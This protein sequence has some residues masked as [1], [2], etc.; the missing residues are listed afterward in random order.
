MKTPRLLSLLLFAALVS[1]R[2]VMAQ[3]APTFPEL[4]DLR[5][6]LQAQHPSLIAGDSGL[7]AAVVVIDTTGRYVRS[8]AFRLEARALSDWGAGVAHSVSLQDDTLSKRLFTAC[9]DGPREG[10]PSAR[11]VCILDGARVRAVDGMRFLT[12]RDIDVLK[13]EAATSRFGPDAASGAVVVT[14]DSVALARFKSVGATPENFVSFEGRRIRRRADGQPVIITVL[15][16]R[17]TPKPPV[18]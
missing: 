12:S 9:F 11:P 18:P 15:M 5:A 7:N 6:W 8:S 3:T 2:G 14:T 10:P 4:D 16:L 17:G 1:S 13:G